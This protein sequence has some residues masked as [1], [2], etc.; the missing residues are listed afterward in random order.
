MNIS[1]TQEIMIFLELVNVLEK[2]I[3]FYIISI[4]QNKACTSFQMEDQKDKFQVH[5]KDFITK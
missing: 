4:F 5:D 2:H 3:T 1:E